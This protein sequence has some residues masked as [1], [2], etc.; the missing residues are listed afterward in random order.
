MSE[1]HVLRRA[2]LV[3]IDLHVSLIAQP[4][5][6]LVKQASAVALPRLGFCPSVSFRYSDCGIRVD[7]WDGAQW[8]DAAVPSDGSIWY[9]RS[10]GWVRR[11]L[12]AAALTKRHELTMRA[13]VPELGPGSYAAA[14]DNVP[15]KKPVPDPEEFTLLAELEP[16]FAL[17]GL[18]ADA[19]G[20]TQ[21]LSR[22]EL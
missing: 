1:S 16:G 17:A 2:R 12:G 22:D 10:D 4:D 6:E 5:S 8:V 15:K 19:D 9:T 11:N 13:S 21:A 3:L 18:T 7:T 20:T 14:S